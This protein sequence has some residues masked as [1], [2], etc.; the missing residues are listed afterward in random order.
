MKRLLVLGGGTA[1]TMVVN[2]LRKKLKKDQWSITVVDKD[3]DHIY[4][5]GLLLLPFGVYQ[6]EELV[7]K[8]DHFFP[9]NVE[10][11]RAEIDKV[12]PEAN[13]VLLTD[14]RI[15]EYDQL[16]IATGTSPRPDQTPGMND[17][18]KLVQLHYEMRWRLG[19]ADDLSYI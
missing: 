6:A 8:R 15:L 16:V 10:F 11:I 3:D 5:P 14:G 2:K 12:L 1:G 9:D 19:K 7:K 17:P 13:H 4:Q 18:L